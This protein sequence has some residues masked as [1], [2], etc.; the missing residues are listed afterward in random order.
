MVL[1]VADQATSVVALATVAVVLVAL[2][3]VVRLM[4]IDGQRGLMV[5][6]V[7]MAVA[8]AAA[9]HRLFLRNFLRHL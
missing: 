9:L 8:V 6:P 7:L 5:V 3:S 1:A 2:E 4:V